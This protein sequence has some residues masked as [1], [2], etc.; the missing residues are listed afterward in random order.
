[1]PLLIASLTKHGPGGA[2]ETARWQAQET[3]QREK[4]AK[5]KSLLTEARLHLKE[6][7]AATE[8]ATAAA[9]AAEAE[10]AALLTANVRL[11][12]LGAEVRGLDMGSR[13]RLSASL[14][15]CLASRDWRLMDSDDP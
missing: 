11:R 1:M 9:A 14:I 13:L 7:A 12:V 5:M 8:A 2:Q 6:K 15:R 10:P 3:A 4:I